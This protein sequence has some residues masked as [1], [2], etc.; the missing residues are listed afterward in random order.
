MCLCVADQPH[1]TPPGQMASWPR[2]WPHLGVLPPRAPSGAR[3]ACSPWPNLGGPWLR[4][5][6]ERLRE[7]HRRFVWDE[8]YGRAFEA[9]RDAVLRKV[10][11]SS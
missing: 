9:V 6:R 10:G 8:Q 2:L 1:I 7:V 4:P 5:R 3:E 11:P